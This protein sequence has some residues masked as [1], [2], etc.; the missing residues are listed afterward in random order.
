[1]YGHLVK[2]LEVSQSENISLLLRMYLVQLA[3]C[4]FIAD[5]N[6]LRIEKSVF[7]IQIKENDL[8]K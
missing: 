1:M 2:F 4:M 3:S 7:F 8:M 6:Q 5:L